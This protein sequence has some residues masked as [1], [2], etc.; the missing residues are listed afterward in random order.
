FRLLFENNPMPMWVFDAGTMEFLSV[1]D[2]AVQHYGYSRERFLGMTL[3]EIWP[4]DERGVHSAAL[5]EIGD[6]YQSSRDWRHIR[7]DGTEI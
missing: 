5:R 7:A 3:R 1:N 2:A 6:V 4:E